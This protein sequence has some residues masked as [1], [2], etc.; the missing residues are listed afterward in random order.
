MAHDA[1][2]VVV[3][4]PE[5]AGGVIDGLFEPRFAQF[6]AVRAPQ[7]RGVLRHAAPAASVSSYAA[8]AQ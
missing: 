5:D 1:E 3:R 2:H 4:Q 6:G 8:I 7:R